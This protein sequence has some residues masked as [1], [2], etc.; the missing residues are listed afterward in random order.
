MNESIPEKELTSSD[1]MP[2]T[3]VTADEPVIQQPELK[4]ESASLTQENQKYNDLSQRLTDRTTVPIKQGTEI[5]KPINKVYSPWITA[6]ALVKFDIDE[7]QIM[8]AIHPP[9]S[10]VKNEHKTICLLSFPDSNSFS[11]EGALKYVFRL[12]KG[13]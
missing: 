7:G 12:K 1:Q 13:T 9:N 6:L 11:A 5:I 10:F 8:E 3:T 4:D 2:E